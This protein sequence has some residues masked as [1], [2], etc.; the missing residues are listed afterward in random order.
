MNALIQREIA[1]LNTFKKFPR[2]RQQGLY[3]GPGGYHPTKDAKLSVLQDVLKILRYIIPREEEEDFLNRP[4]LWHHDLHVDNIFVDENNPSQ[5]T[6]IIDW[7]GVPIYPMFLTARQPTAIEHDWPKPDEFI[8]PTLPSNISKLEPQEQK[9]ERKRHLEQSL[10]IMY[11]GHTQIQA[12]NLL[13]AF[14][15]AE[16]IPCQILRLIGVVFD[17][18]EP[19]VQSFTS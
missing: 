11:E 15:H 14:R 18:G 1:C 8:K 10:W 7:Q 12:P 3:R 9:K 5:I 19:H 13:H 17:D 6:S 2:D 16:T 4:I